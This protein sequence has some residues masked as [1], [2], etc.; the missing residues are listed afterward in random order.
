MKQRYV[1]GLAALLA[2]LGL[3]VFAYK[4]LVLGFPVKTDQETPV[5]AIESSIRFDSGPGSIK[6]NLHI[7]TLT[8]GFRMLS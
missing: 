1:Y 3:S 4:W 8:P 7:P 2:F 5:W 6:V